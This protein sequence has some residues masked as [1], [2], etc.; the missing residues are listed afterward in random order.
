MNNP[1]QISHLVFK[2]QQRVIGIFIAP[3]YSEA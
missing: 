1:Q 3:M 2:K